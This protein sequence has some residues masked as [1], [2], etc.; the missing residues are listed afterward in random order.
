MKI[1]LH[2][3]LE[4]LEY[5]LNMRRDVYPRLVR[6]GK[7]RAGEA[8]LHMRRMEAAWRTLKWLEGL[9]DKHERAALPEVVRRHCG[10]PATDEGAAG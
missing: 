4:E 1:T 5:E 10:R 8:E 6:R 2:A 3:Q 7:L 9:L